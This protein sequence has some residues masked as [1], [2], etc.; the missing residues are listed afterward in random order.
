[1]KWVSDFIASALL[2][3][4][5]GAALA[6]SYCQVGAQ[7]W[8]AGCEASCTAG[9]E[10]SDC[11][12]SCTASPP[13]GYVIVDHRLQVHSQNNGGHDVSRVASGQKFNYRRQVEQAYSYAIEA[14][15]KAG[16]KAAEGKLREEMRNAISEA[17]SFESTHQLVRLSV[18]ASKHGSFI[19]R[20]RGWSKVSVQ[21]LTRCITPDNLSEQL[22]KKHALQ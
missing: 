15:G 7:D 11:P 3:G 10:G 13:P 22:M 21:M 18:S 17:E 5:S 6:Q 8:R 2:V 1:M 9:W 20:K 19:D 4:A 14:A 16:N 12:R